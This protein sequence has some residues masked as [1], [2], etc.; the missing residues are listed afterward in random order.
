M[1]YTTHFYGAVDITP[2]LNEH[3]IS[4]LED[5]NQTIHQTYADDRPLAVYPA[6]TPR[7]GLPEVTNHFLAPAP[8][9]GIHCGWTVSEDG[10]ELVTAGDSDHD[11]DHPEWLAFLIEHLFDPENPDALIHRHRG[12]DPRLKHFTAHTFRGVLAAD[13]EGDDDDW[14]IFVGDRNTSYTAPGLEVGIMT[15]EDLV[16]A[17]SPQLK[18]SVTRAVTTGTTND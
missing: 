11:Y 9:P 8:K 4:Y 16:E 17:A 2:P 3:E 13:G 15:V 12:D 1:G 10:S 6:G 18:T 5:F 7:T 14:Y